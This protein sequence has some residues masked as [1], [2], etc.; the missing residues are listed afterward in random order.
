MKISIDLEIG[1]DE[2][3]LATELVATLRQLTSHVSIKQVLPLAATC[4]IG[5]CHA[6]L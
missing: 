5:M 6:K 4:L 2:I 3:G 1:P